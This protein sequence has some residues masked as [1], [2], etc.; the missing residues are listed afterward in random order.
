MGNNTKYNPMSKE[1]QE[2]A[3]EL[4]LTGRQYIKKLVDEGKMVN[5]TDVEKKRVNE[6]AKR[7]GFKDYN[8]YIRKE[9]NEYKRNWKR[10]YRWNKGIS[11]PMEFNESCPSYFGVSFGEELFRRFLLTIFEHV[12]KT[13]YIDKGI[14]FI[15]KSPKYEFVDKHLQFK[16]ERDKEYSMQLKVRRLQSVSMGNDN[17]HFP[18]NY[19]HIPDYFILVG[20]N[21]REDLNPAHIWLIYKDD[22]IRG[23]KFWR[24]NSFSVVN[25]P[26][27]IIEFEKYELKDELEIINKLCN[28]LK[29]EM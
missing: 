5:P 8:E 14:D 15:C 22:I 2:R 27:H 23:R 10:Q 11:E 17:F 18:I 21:N 20:F 4:G 12:K 7:F 16:L 29:E 9:R 19:N 24:R 6:M 25:V 13:G 26:Q 3:K 28:Q 1:F